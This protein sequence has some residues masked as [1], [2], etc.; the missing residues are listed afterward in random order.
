MPQF[1]PNLLNVRIDLADG[2]LIAAAIHDGHALRPATLRHMA[3]SEGERLREE[4][5]FTGSWTVVAPT[6]I[7]GKASRF[8]VD[9]NRP[10]DGAVYL[11]P[12]QA[13]GLNVWATPPGDDVLTPS[14]VAYDAFYERIAALL[15]E[16]IRRHRKVVVYDLHS[17][18]HRRDGA[19]GPEADPGQNPQINLGTGTLAD[20]QPWAGL[21]DRF[22]AT[23]SAERRPDG[24]RYDVRENI[25][26][27]GGQFGRWIHARYPGDV[28]VLSIEVKK[29]F[30]DEWTGRPIPAEIDAVRTALAATTSGVLADLAAM[31]GQ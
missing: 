15:D 4:D 21:I 26:F 22:I 5:P 18:N 30:M 27:K 28:C 13:W 29:F 9:L 24:T 10:R 11:T 3:L 25:K 8:E 31:G 17:Y 16:K 23:F 1:D 14:L 7:V 12:Q 6:R 19:T 2:P 20:R